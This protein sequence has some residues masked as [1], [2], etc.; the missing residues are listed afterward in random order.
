MVDIQL[1]EK[2][3][4]IRASEK[5][6]TA[7]DIARN[8]K[9]NKNNCCVRTI[10]NILIEGGLKARRKTKLNKEKRLK[11]AKKFKNWK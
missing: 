9:I 3:Q 8:S 4:I 2:T 10:R 5:N 6:I 11:W 7:A 1:M